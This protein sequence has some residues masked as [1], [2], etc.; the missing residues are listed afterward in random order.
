MS[1]SE[2]LYLHY[3]AQCPGYRYMGSGARGLADA[4]ERTCRQID[5]QV[6]PEHAARYRM[7]FPGMVVVDEFQLV[8]PGTVQQMLESYR[9]LGPIS[10]ELDWRESPAGGVGEVVPLAAERAEEAAGICLGDVSSLGVSD[11]KDWLFRQ[12]ETLREGVC[13]FI[14]R[15]FGQPVGGVEFVLE[16]RVPYPIP[17]RREGWVFLTCLYSSSASDL[18][19]RL[20]MLRALVEG[21]RDLGYRGISAVSG[22]ETPY[23]N[24]PRGTFEEAGFC[25]G[26]PLGRALLRSRWEFM[27]FMQMSF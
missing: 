13:G 10:G 24:G 15:S 17:E 3:G 4:L 11:K 26:P 8:Y 14:G 25:T 20:A 9:S 23:P 7:F 1:S 12:E 19:Y 18:D 5:V 2:V 27:R 22:E 16:S 6:N 21:V